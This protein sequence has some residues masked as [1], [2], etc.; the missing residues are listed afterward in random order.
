MIFSGK[1]KETFRKYI[2]LYENG[3]DDPDVIKAENCFYDGGKVFMRPGI[4]IDM[5]KVVSYNTN[6]IGADMSLI[7]TDSYIYYDGEYGRVVITVKDTLAKLITFDLK[8][9]TTKGKVLPL[10]SI[11]FSSVD[12]GFFGVPASYTVFSGTPI[13]GKGI[14]FMVRQH[15]G[16]TVDD[17]VKVFELTDDGW[18]YLIES[19]FYTPTILANGRG[20]GYYTAKVNDKPLE[21][22]TPVRPEGRNLLSSQ[23]I[24]YYTTDS[25][26]SC[27]LLP[28]K[29]L[30]SSLVK[31]EAMVNG[32]TYTWYIPSD[33]DKSG[34]VTVDGIGVTAY[35]TRSTGRVYFRKVDG[36]EH[37][38]KYEQKL[39]NLKITASKTV[40]NAAA[41]LASKMAACKLE[42]DA[43]GFKS[44]VT[45]FYGGDICPAEVY[46]NSP[47]H[48]LYFSENNFANLG[49]QGIGIEKM[50]VRGNEVLAFKEN[51]LFSAGIKKSNDAFSGVEGGADNREDRYEVAFLSKCNL[52]SKPIGSTVCSV[53]NDIYF[54]TEE[55]K[56]LKTSASGNIELVLTLP[57]SIEGG[58]A[59]CY[60]GAY[61][62]VSKNI[63]WLIKGEKGK[64]GIFTWKLPF[65]LSYGIGYLSDVVF[66]TAYEEYNMQIV[67]MAY[68]SGN[69]D[70]VFNLNAEILKTQKSGIKAE[71]EV[72]PKCLSGKHKLGGLAIDFRA[73][74]DV[75]VSISDK[76]GRRCE[77]TLKA[78]NEKGFTT[79]S[80][81]TDSPRFKFGFDGDF[82]IQR[83][84]VECRKMNKL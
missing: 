30:D 4:K 22:P 5:K 61:M 83:F 3:I 48:P 18:E 73:Q 50:V 51:K 62:L 32:N 37:K 84:A 47:Y 44:N 1:E 74:K 35:C 29:G 28:V 21:L 2:T 80:I 13:Q 67:Y 23:F 15:Y 78:K 65:D 81:L 16:G 17:F 7:T 72:S 33:S 58:F 70:E 27:F 42:G 14:F 10:G 46:W 6:N 20:E 71:L 60:K 52:D 57:Q 68:F 26:S 45:L 77:H 82:E 79:L 34:L 63:A 38:F 24:C 36:S 41:R 55:G 39:N 25:E 49:E 69:E 53:G 64:H 75:E 54:T 12:G 43:Y 40:K 56:V 9:V 11:D 8:V 31:C 59:V 19:Q 76:G 66:F